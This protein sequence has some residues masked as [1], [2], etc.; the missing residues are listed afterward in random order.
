MHNHFYIFTY[1]DSNSYYI[2]FTSSIDN[3]LFNEF[4]LF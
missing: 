1:I 4:G 3:E 2:S